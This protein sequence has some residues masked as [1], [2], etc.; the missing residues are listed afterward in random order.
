M[1]LLTIGLIAAG[2]YCLGG[3][4]NNS[5]NNRKRRRHKY[6]CNGLTFDSWADVENYKN[7]VG[8]K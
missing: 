7:S 1:D 2:L 4:D 5:K 6:H 8:L 3:G